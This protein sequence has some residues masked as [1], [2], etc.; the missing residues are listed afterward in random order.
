MREQN[1]NK[2]YKKVTL[3]E[4]NTSAIKGTN[5]CSDRGK[6]G[7]GEYWFNGV[8]RKGLSGEVEFKLEHA[9]VYDV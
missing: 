5:G 3:L 8:V 1:R 7:L 6:C 2:D 4:V 9:N